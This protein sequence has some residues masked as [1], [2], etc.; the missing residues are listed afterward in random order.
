MAY[1][2]QFIP[3][4][5]QVL[6]GT[7]DQYQKASD[8]ETNRQNQASDVYSA[9][10]TTRT[11][12]TAKKNETMGVFEAKLSELDKKYN[13]DRSN[14][15]YAKELA[16]EI[17]GLRSNP[18]WAHI[19]QKDEI[20]KV[21]TNLI[22]N[23]GADYYENFN[24][25]D[26]TL[27]NAKNL[28]QWKPMDLKDL[29]RQVAT[30]AK[31]HATSIRGPQQINRPAPGVLEI[32]NQVG[33]PTVE[34]ATEWLSQPEGQA[35]LEQSVKGT[36]FEGHLGDPSVRGR[37]VNAALSQLVG[38]P[39]RK[40][41]GD[42]SYDNGSSRGSN[43]PLNPRWGKTTNIGEQKAY[44]VTALSDVKSLKEELNAVNTQIANPDITDQERSALRQKQNELQLGADRIENLYDE[45]KSTDTAKKVIESGNAMLRRYFPSLSKEQSA[46]V[47]ENIVDAKVNSTM[48]NDNPL[49]TALGT[50][51]QFFV[52]RL[53][54]MGGVKGFAKSLLNPGEASLPAAAESGQQF[55]EN[56]VAT[57]MIYN[58][59]GGVYQDAKEGGSSDLAATRRAM[60]F[61]DEIDNFYKGQGNF[62]GRG[63]NVIEKEFNKK[64][65]SGET[66]VADVYSP[67]IDIPSAELK[68]IPTFVVN[69]LSAF[70]VRKDGNSTDPMT[71]REVEKLTKLFEK[72]DPSVQVSINRE[73]EPTLIL[74]APSGEKFKL[75]MNIAKM[76]TDAAEQL[77]A[78][79][80]LPQI[81]DVLYT[82]INFTNNRTYTL[83]DNYLKNIISQRY[84]DS[85]MFEGLAIVQNKD[86]NGISYT[87]V[88]PKFTELY[89]S[90]AVTF[91]SKYGLMRTL[92]EINSRFTRSW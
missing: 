34:K 69:N 1:V 28:Q 67:P 83:D 68:K 73:S 25:N 74:R 27:D 44:P 51:G 75:K 47:M 55:G 45:V 8:L 56:K 18:L 43:P 26:L 48:L 84:K 61:I 9:I 72:G 78:M 71:D 70:D 3:T 12:D 52:N 63:F 22:A 30:V 35:W 90:K 5:T 50:T 24:P 54:N 92:D 46:A 31:E 15:Q 79:T 41:M 76:S 21:R 32:V 4:N 36:G 16:K 49:G 13:Y 2:P 62:A 59:A 86:E 77:V 64:A 20:D 66:F 40:I 81:M 6:Q 87:A 10:P 29:E 65:K 85:S 42:P 14:T 91:N 23:K 7:L 57:E 82:D 11:Y 19:Q 39:D 17:T 88:L 37:V 53:K 80:G 89:G 60:K 33:F 38:E 58:F